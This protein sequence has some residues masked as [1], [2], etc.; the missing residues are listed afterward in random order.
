MQID[1]KETERFYKFNDLLACNGGRK[2]GLDILRTYNP[3]T[4][5][6]VRDDLSQGKTRTSSLSPYI[7]FGCISIREAYHQLNVPG[8]VA[9]IKQL[10]WRDYFIML[11][12]SSSTSMLH[13]IV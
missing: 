10:F 6:K 9:M 7:K 8:G 2:N 11:G 3:T 5:Q 13:I 1:F 4:Y 12:K